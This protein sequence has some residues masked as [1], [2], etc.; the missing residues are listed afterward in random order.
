MGSGLV[1][2]LKAQAANLALMPSP[3]NKGLALRSVPPAS[4]LR[5]SEVHMQVQTTATAKHRVGWLQHSRGLVEPMNI[6]NSLVNQWSQIYEDS[7]CFTK[8][9]RWRL[10]F[11]CCNN[12]QAFLKEITAIG[13]EHGETGL[14]T[15]MQESLC[16]YVCVCI[17][18]SCE[19]KQTF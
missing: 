9:V 7:R 6:A 2:A 8:Q 4:R 15:K 11:S 14:L 17:R 12:S 13:V 18:R 3:S 5:L 16:T 1:S 10:Q 19:F